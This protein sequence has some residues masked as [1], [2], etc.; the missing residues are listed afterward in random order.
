M[1]NLQGAGN[2]L[3]NQLMHASIT[4]DVHQ[5]SVQKQEQTNMQQ[6]ELQKQVDKETKLQ[7]SAERRK[8]LTTRDTVHELLK[9]DPNAFIGVPFATSS[10][11]L[12][13][14]VGSKM[15]LSD[16]YKQ[17]DKLLRSKAYI[18]ANGDTTDARKQLKI[19]KENAMKSIDT[20]L[21]ADIAK[22]RKDKTNG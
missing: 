17:Q 15:Q 19:S 18:K 22:L 20:K 13:A 6:A 7:K 1:T 10:K 3:L 16:L 4:H 2:A 11:K 12:Y 9:N 5:M 14:A 21:A 8:R